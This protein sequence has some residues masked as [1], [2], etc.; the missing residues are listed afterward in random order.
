MM[1]SSLVRAVY[2]RLRYYFAWIYGLL[3]FILIW[4]EHKW[5]VFCFGR[6]LRVPLWRL[7]IHDAA[8]FHP[9]EVFGYVAGYYLKD[10]DG[11][12]T[13]AASRSALLK[14]AYAHHCIRCTH[15][16]EHYIDE[17]SPPTTSGATPA[18]DGQ[19]RPPV[20]RAMPP[21]CVREM[22]ADW[23]HHA[24]HSVIHVDMY[25]C[26]CMYVVCSSIIVFQTI[27]EYMV[28]VIVDQIIMDAC[29]TNE[30]ISIG[31]NM[32]RAQCE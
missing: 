11:S 22:I 10:N 26:D 31:V 13:T 29:Y 27:T 16:S 8:K 3:R 14:A 28:T 15:H 23:V 25:C 2:D 19:P 1:L 18:A 12:L 21:D 20:V 17:H 32:V 4:L 6:L 5:Y 24:H 9:K 7:L 30:R